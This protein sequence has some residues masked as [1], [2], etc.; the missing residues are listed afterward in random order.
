[1]KRLVVLFVLLLAAP[2]L[3]QQPAT[4]VEKGWFAAY[5]YN[6]GADLAYAGFGSW[7]PGGQTPL[8][9]W[10]SANHDAMDRCW[11]E[12]EDE[13]GQ[14]PPRGLG[15]QRLHRRRRRRQA[16]L[17]LGMGGVPR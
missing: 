17:G 13:G 1:M 4:A 16:G 3:V 11:E 5:A 9:A 12:A 8:Q 2:L 10:R 6:P 7:E 15:L 14:L